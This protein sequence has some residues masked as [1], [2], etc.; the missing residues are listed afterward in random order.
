VAEPPKRIVSLNLCA[1][2]YLLALTNT[3]V[4]LTH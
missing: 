2:Q 3:I 4:Q 1:D